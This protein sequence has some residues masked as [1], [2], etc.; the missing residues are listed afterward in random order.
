M[1]LVSPLCTS[2]LTP[3]SSSENRGGFVLIC[4]YMY[5]TFTDFSPSSL[6]LRFPPH[7]RGK[8]KEWKKTHK[9]ALA[10]LYVR[11]FLKDQNG[12]PPCFRGESHKFQALGVRRSHDKNLQYCRIHIQKCPKRCQCLRGFFCVLHF[13]F[14]SLI[15]QESK[16][17]WVEMFC[18]SIE[19]RWILFVW[20]NNL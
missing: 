17:F 1:R 16:I 20:G 18:F 19:A 8:T 2:F 5:H 13:A 4:W 9:K 14:I 6:S 3:P 12:L 10:W 7:A 11:G 15:I